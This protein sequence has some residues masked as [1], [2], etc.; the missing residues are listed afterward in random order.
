M[1]LVNLS[2]DRLRENPIQ[3]EMRTA[4][5]K[6]KQLRLSIQANGLLQPVTV[7]RASAGYY[8]ILDGHRRVSC[9]KMLNIP[10][11]PCIIY[12][13]EMENIK[14]IDLFVRMNAEKLTLSSTFFLN[15]YLHGAEVPNKI[16][17]LIL[18][19]TEKTN[20]KF[21]KYMVSHNINPYSLYRMHPFFKEQV[22]KNN[23]EWDFEWHCKWAAKNKYI[24]V[25]ANRSKMSRFDGGLPSALNPIKIL[26]LMKQDWANG[27]KF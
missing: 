3:P 20:R 9:C 18:F 2:I 21:L 1:E 12:N 25:L 10:E 22:K 19:I 13:G 14:D 16:V 26:P 7:S 17:K 5:S 23:I 6:L 11:I 4:P 27:V 8:I 24:R 15:A